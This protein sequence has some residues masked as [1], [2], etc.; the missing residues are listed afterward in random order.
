MT[1]SLD[2]TI[3]NDLVQL[4]QSIPTTVNARKTARQ[5]IQYS[6]TNLMR[7]RRM[8]NS[9]EKSLNKLQTS[10]SICSLIA[11]MLEKMQRIISD[12]GN[13]STPQ[14]RDEVY[15]Y[16]LEQ[17][18]HELNATNKICNEVRATPIMQAELRRQE[19][20]AAELNEIDIES[21]G[22]PIRCPKCGKRRI[23]KQ[24]SL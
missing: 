16:L 12:Q 21:L 18:Q 10:I 8:L 20:E 9:G 7:V 5:I 13:A 17:I 6:Q 22:V 4:D 15:V 14:E 23:V 24:Q 2:S 3:L 19:Q 11:H 1:S